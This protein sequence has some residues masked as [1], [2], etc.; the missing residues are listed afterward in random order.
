MVDIDKLRE[1]KEALKE[2]LITQEEYE[3]LKENV[4][5]ESNKSQ[6][7]LPSAIED[8]VSLSSQTDKK[9]N[10]RLIFGVVGSIILFFGAFAPVIGHPMG[11]LPLQ[12][13]AQG[14]IIACSVASLILTIKRFYRWLVLTG[15][16]AGLTIFYILFNFFT[17]IADA[18][19]DIN[20]ELAD[21]PFRR[22]ADAAVDSVHLEWGIGLLIIGVGLIF[23]SAYLTLFSKSTNKNFSSKLSYFKLFVI[24]FF[25]PSGKINIINIVLH[26]FYLV[27]LS[28][29]LLPLLLLLL[30]YG[31][32]GGNTFGT[33]EGFVSD[34]LDCLMFLK[35]IGLLFSPLYGIR[36]WK[37]IK[38]IKKL[39]QSSLEE[40]SHK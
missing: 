8:N 23:Y 39:N 25:K 35:I 33:A 30:D 9:L 20:A 1:L 22:F 32:N 27:V 36:I 13:G 26:V 16:A 5:E 17:I 7:N 28:L 12:N 6:S 3:R 11:S 19:S 24:T 37:T 29:P 4:I 14:I 31:F 38:K 21:N 40:C 18:K 10:L 15:T 2:E 34:L